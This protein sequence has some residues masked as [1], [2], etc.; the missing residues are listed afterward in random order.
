MTKIID[1]FKKVIEVPNEGIK[2]RREKTLVTDFLKERIDRVLISEKCLELRIKEMANELVKE[3][4]QSKKELY[5]VSILKGSV[6]FA[7]DLIR[8][9]NFDVNLD[10][11]SV[12]SYVGRKPGKKLRINLEPEDVEG[13]DI[14]LLEDILDTG[15]TLNFV[16]EYFL[17]KKKARSVKI[18]AL[19]DKPSRR[20]KEINADFVGFSIPDCFVV[21]CGLDYNQHFR[22]L[23]FIA[24]FKK[25]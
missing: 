19:L 23:P 6:I 20:E 3:I 25:Y 17:K 18:C 12:S 13:K 24:V 7:A 1:N 15:N 4:R 21:G 10:F 22:N 5:I 9:I 2:T 16:K 14:V 8:N 11:L